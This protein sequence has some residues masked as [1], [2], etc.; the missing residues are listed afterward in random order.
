MSIAWSQST[1]TK[2]HSFL[3]VSCPGLV[4]PV[5]KFREMRS[6]WI[7]ISPS[8]CRLAEGF[9]IA[10]PYMWYLVFLG[11]HE[12]KGVPTHFGCHESQALPPL[13]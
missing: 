3:C 9:S 11:A 6:C 8:Q 13:R 10:S 1:K 4:T 12:G 7:G 2:G 5:I